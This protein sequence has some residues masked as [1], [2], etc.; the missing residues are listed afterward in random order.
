MIGY[1]TACVL[2][3]VGIAI[4][5][6]IATMSQFRHFNSAKKGFEWTWKITATHTVFPMIGYYLLI[7]LLLKLPYLS[8]ALGLLAFL[9][10]GHLLFTAY[11][12]WFEEEDDISGS[13]LPWTLIFAVSWDALFSGPAKAAQAQGWSE[14]Q[15][16][17]SFP[18][19]GIVVGS[20]AIFALW[21]AQQTRTKWLEGN[22]S[23]VTMSSRHVIAFY[24]EFV[25]LGY[26]GVLALSR[27][28][29]KLDISPMHI[30][31]VWAVFCAIFFSIKY[32]K[33]KDA[34]LKSL[35]E[36]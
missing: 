5:V 35:L 23:F 12:E 21:L 16:I 10:I 27:L 26:F 30:I 15:I 28:V 22:I 17:I 34:H 29:F 3:G 2:M 19:A 6:F 24:F 7:V 8:I 33:L 20:V 9:L 36:E 4:D 1:I 11:K 31:L 25:V 13:T 32:N 14:F 18:I